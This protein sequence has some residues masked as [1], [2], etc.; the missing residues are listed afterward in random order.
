MKYSSLLLAS[1]QGMLG[2]DALQ[3]AG[4]RELLEVERS[5]EMDAVN[6][7]Y[8]I[9]NRAVWAAEVRMTKMMMDWWTD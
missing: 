5:V 4:V 2:C 9:V 1:Y 6:S 8:R 3:W 7:E